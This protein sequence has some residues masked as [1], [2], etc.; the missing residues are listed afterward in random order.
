[1]SETC[2][3]AV[4]GLRPAVVHAPIHRP[5]RRHLGGSDHRLG[6]HRFHDA[7]SASHAERLTVCPHRAA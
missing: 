4:I 5:N 7:C 1:M 2:D 6:F 3:V